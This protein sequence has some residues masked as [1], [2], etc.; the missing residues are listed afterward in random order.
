MCILEQCL[1]V[2]EIPSYN[3]GRTGVFHKM[4]TRLFTCLV[5]CSARS[6]PAAV[7]LALSAGVG[8][9]MLGVG[10]KGA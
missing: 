7:F 9:S 6:S 1:H 2:P 4:P 8:E 3:Y 10:L 5:N